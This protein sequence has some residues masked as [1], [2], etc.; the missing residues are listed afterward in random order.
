MLFNGILIALVKDLLT[1]RELWLFKAITSCMVASFLSGCGLV[2]PDMQRFPHVKDDE[3]FEEA[4][5]VK[6]IKCEIQTGI[7]GAIAYLH[8]QPDSGNSI[9]W[10]KNAL[11]KVTLNLSVDDKTSLTPGLTLTKPVENAISYFKYYGNVTTQQ[12]FSTIL[13]LQA[14]ADA[15][16]S[17]L[18]AYTYKVAEMLKH[19]YNSPCDHESPVLI[20][21]DLK[22]ADFILNKAYIAYVPDL[23]FGQ[24]PF[25]T[26]SDTVTFI[27]VSGGSVTPVWKLVNITGSSNTP[28][29]NAVR[30]RTDSVIISIAQA[31]STTAPGQPPQLSAEGEAINNA[32]LIGQAVAN[33]LRQGLTVTPTQ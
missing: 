2:V 29:V 10:L 17:E 26:F 14:S 6:Q 8:S 19:P 16:R 23:V 28:F 31:G 3:K 32:Q 12:S 22:I 13:G 25:T 5:L 20:Y 30:T 21:S 9:E 18:I 15:T 4:I 1:E 24:F 11:V 7:Q 27:V 33:A